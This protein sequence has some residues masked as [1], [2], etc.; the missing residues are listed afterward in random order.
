MYVSDV[1]MCVICGIC[2]CMC[3]MCIYV[4]C[5]Y[6]Y[7]MCIC[8]CVYMCLM[9]VCVHTLRPKKDVRHPSLSPSTLFPEDSL[10]VAGSQQA[11]PSSCLYPT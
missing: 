10:T 4:V 2:V 5:V 6:V 9:C 3:V 7:D 8:E 11:L 1:C